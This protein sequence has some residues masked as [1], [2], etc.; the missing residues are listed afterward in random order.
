MAKIRILLADDHG[1]VCAGLKMILQAEADLEVVGQAESVRDLLREASLHSPDVVCLDLNLADGSGLKA[2]APLRAICPGVK[3]LVVTAQNDSSYVHA[4]LAAGVNGYLSKTAPE[5]EFLSAIRAVHHNRIVVNLASPEEPPVKLPRAPRGG[6]ASLSPREKEVLKLLA[7]GLTNQQAADRLF[8]SVK[9]VETHRSRLTSKLGL[10]DRADLMLYAIETG[11]LL[12]GQD[13][14]G[15]AHPE[16]T[17]GTTG[18][19]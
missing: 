4:A 7:L 19:E 6:N 1:I 12:A 11:M 18:D 3:I 17:G 5:N 14:A 13:V 8:L 16:H 10:R 9:T 15:R 2:V